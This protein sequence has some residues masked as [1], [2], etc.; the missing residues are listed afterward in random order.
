MTELAEIP[1]SRDT[2]PPSQPPQG[3]QQHDDQGSRKLLGRAVRISRV[4]KIG[5]VY[6]LAAIIVLFSVW[7]PELFPT[8]AT[9]KSVLN[10]NSI[11]ALAALALIVPL[12]TGVYD[13]SIGYV[14]ALCSVLLAALIV[15]HHVAIPIA[16]AIALSMSLVVGL[17]NAFFVVIVGIDSFIVTLGTGSL[18]QAV[19][20][21][22]SNDETVTNA[23]MNTQLGKVA[24][25]ELIGLQIPVF[26][27]I[28]VVLLLWWLLERTVTGRRLYATGFNEEA[29]RLAG[30]RTRRLRF[31]GLMISA[32]VAALAGLMLTA[33]IGAGDPDIGPAYLLDAFAAAFLGA[34]QIRSGRFNA[35][36]TVIAVLVLGTGTAGLT[37]IGA[38]AWAL[39][40]YT[41][42][43]LLIA[44]A[45]T[46]LERQQVRTGRAS[47]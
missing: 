26:V 37:L 25:T 22:I 28:G 31:G 8:T 15:E 16:I 11:A 32:V 19:N 38:Q 40:M 24:T 2:P 20:L 27:V 44:L 35:V 14:M 4:D 18:L 47:S 45:L 46:K 42:V 1:S 5:A 43:V 12:A 41:G 36:G 34:T 33:Q 17:V 39:N 30:V 13:L 29:A 3:N 7:K 6:V 9:V 23:Q 21:L 10:E